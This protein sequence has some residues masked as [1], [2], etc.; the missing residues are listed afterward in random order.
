MN[1]CMYVCISALRMGK[2]LGEEISRDFFVLHESLFGPFYGFGG[3]D[4]GDY[5]TKTTNT[6]KKDT[7]Y[8]R[9]FSKKL[10]YR[11]Q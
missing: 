1:V 7:A 6:T 4:G 8:T 3:D 5:K 11:M 2:T 10:I 9:Y